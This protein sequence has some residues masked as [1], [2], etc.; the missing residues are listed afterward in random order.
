LRGFAIEFGCE[1]E[2]VRGVECKVLFILGICCEEEEIIFVDFNKE[3]F[4][5]F[6]GDSKIFDEIKS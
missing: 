5:F 2:F 4:S 1:K 3:E 6:F